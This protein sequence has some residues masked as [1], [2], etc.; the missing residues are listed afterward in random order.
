VGKGLLA[1]G[2]AATLVLGAMSPPAQAETLLRF[3]IAKVRL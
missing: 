3:P 2:A 1:A